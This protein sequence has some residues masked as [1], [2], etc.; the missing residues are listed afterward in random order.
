MLL[1]IVT[2]GE[3]NDGA[4]SGE[5]VTNEQAVEIDLL[6]TNT[7]T[8]KKRFL[9]YMKV[10]DVQ[11][12]RASDYQKAIILLKPCFSVRKQNQV[13]RVMRLELFNVIIFRIMLKLIKPL[14]LFLLLHPILRIQALLYIKVRLRFGML[15]G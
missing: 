15:M 6:V 13:M 1:N 12:I 5:V 4:D 14:M 7:K 9:D 2:T 11:S 3:D 8:D 10:T